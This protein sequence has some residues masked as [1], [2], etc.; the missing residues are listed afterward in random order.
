MIYL[1]LALAIISV[2]LLIALIHYRSQIRKNCHQLEVMQKH[3]SNQRLTS[4]VPYKEVKELVRRINEICNRY[5]E[6]KI[7]MER[8]ENNLKEAIANLSHD[9]R[10][11]LTSLPPR[12]KNTTFRSSRTVYPA[13]RNFWK[14]SLPIRR[15]RTRTTS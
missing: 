8:N 9:I 13:S 10:T 4:E 11:P 14:N 2:S 15:C 7:I 5:Q 12:K 3:S 6:D 1:V